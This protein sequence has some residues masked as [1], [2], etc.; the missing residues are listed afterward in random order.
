MRCLLVLLIILIGVNLPAQNI[1]WAKQ[2]IHSNSLNQIKGFGVDGQDNVYMSGNFSNSN[3]PSPYKQGWF[4]NKISAGG[5]VLI[6]DS[7]EVPGESTHVLALSDSSLFTMGQKLIKRNLN[8]NGVWVKDIAGKSIASLN[9]KLYLATQGDT[10]FKYDING[11]QI[12]AKP[13]PTSPFKKI[14]IKT[15]NRHIYGLTGDGNNTSPLQLN[16]FDTLGNLLW[17]VQ[18]NIG[19]LWGMAVDTAGST[20]LQS[21]YYMKK[22]NTNGGTVWVIA[23]SNNGDSVAHYNSFIDKD[24]VYACGIYV[25][26]GQRLSVISLY[27]AQTGSFLSRYMFDVVPSKGED[28]QHIIKKGNYVYIAGATAEQYKRL[29]VAKISLSSL[30]AAVK[31][32]SFKESSFTIYPNPTGGMITIKSG[33]LITK[34]ELRVENVLGQLVCTKKI[35]TNGTGIDETINL[36]Q[37][38]KGIYFVQINTGGVVEVRKIVLE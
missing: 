30:P 23:N 12:W 19:Y 21:D 16:K 29:F 7:L 31:S 3:W 18:V 8:G 26:M 36:S 37:Y 11:Q 20:Y 9:N 10:V 25:G 34:G 15:S 35:T 5:A 1:I 2:F 13:I 4:L 6:N 27:S 28:P 22:I 24:T 14:Q 33:S 17:T 32:T 38:P